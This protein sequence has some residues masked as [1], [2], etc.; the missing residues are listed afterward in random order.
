MKV[1]VVLVGA[2]PGLKEALEQ[3]LK[4]VSSKHDIAITESEA[5]DP[6]AA[7]LARMLGVI[8]AELLDEAD[9]LKDE[10]CECEMCVME[11]QARAE[12][13]SPLVHPSIKTEGERFRDVIR[14]RLF[15]DG[16]G[17]TVFFNDLF[18]PVEELNLYTLECEQ[19]AERLYGAR[20]LVDEGGM[21]LFRTV[22]YRS[23]DENALVELE[24]VKGT[25][26]GGDLPEVDITCIA[27]PA[28]DKA[29][30]KRMAEAH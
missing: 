9:I 2:P 8:D 17:N 30:N 27:G 15:D 6:V 23:A 5:R 22:D 28:F 10:P 18:H 13:R 4:E 12:G 20:A 21:A 29:F 7:A 11:R 24:H 3:S 14:Y 26:G 25:V 16:E 19:R 1:S